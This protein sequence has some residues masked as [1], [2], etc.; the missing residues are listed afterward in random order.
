MSHNHTN[1]IFMLTRNDSTITDALDY[2]P[3]V[4]EAGIRHIGYKD[5]GL[6]FQRLVD[7]Q[8][9]I[10]AAGAK[11]YLEVVSLD[12]ESEL[13]S[14][15]S[16]IEL[17]VD[18]LLGGTHPDD[19][20]PLIEGTGIQ[21]YPFPGR[22]EGHPSNLRG[23]SDEIVFSARM[24]AAKTGVH[25]LDLLAYRANVDVLE[26]IKAVC[27]SVDKPVIIA[28][29]IDRDERIHAA[30]QAGAVGFTVGTA[31]FDER[32]PAMVKGLEGQLKHINAVKENA[33]IK[34]I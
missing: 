3:T 34:I 32:F 24:L 14:V 30:V 2:L 17:G 27:E 12:V 25:G 1:F 11:S 16:A 6:P 21:Y 20:L 5:I 8:R 7:L 28:G 26:L 18:Y 9:A 23:S 10:R 15:Q 31:A 19:V 22:I 33:E 4:L 13:R 29:S